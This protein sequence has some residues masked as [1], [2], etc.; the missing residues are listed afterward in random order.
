MM[1]GTV[2]SLFLILWVAAA[3]A[4][5]GTV[6]AQDPATGVV[7]LDSD[8]FITVQETGTGSLISLY[9]VRGDRIY[10]VDTIVNGTSR[11]VN[12]PTRYIH[13]IEVENR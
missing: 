2:V 10:L 8:T 3:M 4:F 5:P 7:A 13:H 1:K 11:D 6:A 12:M 9:Q